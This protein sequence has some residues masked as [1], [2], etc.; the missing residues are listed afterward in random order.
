MVHDI[1]SAEELECSHLGRGELERAHVQ[2]LVEGIP[3]WKPQLPD[4]L[5]VQCRHE[6][7]DPVRLG[8]QVGHDVD[9]ITGS[10][11]AQLRPFPLDDPSEDFDDLVVDGACVTHLPVGDT[12]PHPRLEGCDLVVGRLPHQQ[13]GDMM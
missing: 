3:A 8:Q 13:R 9:A 1:R 4:H 11:D 12:R 5:P 6:E 10:H 2:P 7:A